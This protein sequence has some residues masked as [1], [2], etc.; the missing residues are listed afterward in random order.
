[1]SGLCINWLANFFFR[2]WAITDAG[3]LT[4]SLFLDF[5]LIGVPPGDLQKIEN[6]KV[7]M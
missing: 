1:M 3:S 6:I 2:A 4:D 5:G 7:N